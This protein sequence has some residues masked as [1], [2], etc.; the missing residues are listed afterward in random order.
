[1]PPT[2]SVPPT[3]WPMKSG[4]TGGISCSLERRRQDLVPSAAGADGDAIAAHRSDRVEGRQVEGD[5]GGVLRLA[6][7]R[8]AGAP[9][10]DADVVAPGEAQHAGDVVDR[11]R[12]QH[13]HRPLEHELAVVLPGGIEAGVVEDH[14]PVERWEALERR[15]GGRPADATQLWEP[16]L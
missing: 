12:P 15:A 14:L 13:G 16:T 9:S 8:V 11:A 10:D 2:D 6:E 1:M 7:R 5:A 3:V 4:S